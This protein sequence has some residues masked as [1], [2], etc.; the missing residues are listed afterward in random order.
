MF[1]SN[2]LAVNMLPENYSLPVKK[3]LKPPN[4]L[5][6]ILSKVLASSLRVSLEGSVGLPEYIFPYFA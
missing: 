3:A 6:A 2:F 1:F 4:S 5:F